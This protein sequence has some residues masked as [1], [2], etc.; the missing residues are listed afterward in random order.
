MFPTIEYEK[1][2]IYVVKNHIN[3]INDDSFFKFSVSLCTGLDLYHALYNRE[4]NY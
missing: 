4:R 3:K 2:E 1:G